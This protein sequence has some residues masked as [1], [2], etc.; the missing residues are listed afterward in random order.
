[1]TTSSNPRNPDTPL[2]AERRHPRTPAASA[3]RTLLPYALTIIAA[4]AAVQVLIALTGNRITVFST[5]VLAVVALGYAVYLMTIGRRLSRVRYGLLAAHA[6]SYAAINT[7]YLLH[8]YV[9]IALRSPAIAG[10]G[11][12]AIDPLWL[13]A[14]YGMAG[15]WGIGL[16]IHGLGAI[17]SR[18]FEQ[19]RA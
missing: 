5:V 9:L 15:F 14:T 2:T 7:G 4:S 19:G 10:D 1:M 8:A 16:L 12:L 13:G 17:L 3:H 11:P 18:G 6:I